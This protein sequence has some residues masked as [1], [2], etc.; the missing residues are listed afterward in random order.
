MKYCCI[1]GDLKKQILSKLKQNRK[2]I[3][4]VRL[5]RGPSI[6]SDHYMLVANVMRPTTMPIINLNTKVVKYDK[7]TTYKLLEPE[8]AD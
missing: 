3:L 8:I 4:D 2:F 1:N 7:I 6:G 5:R